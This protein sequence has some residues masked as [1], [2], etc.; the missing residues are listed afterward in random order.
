MRL[1]K[2][3]IDWG[4]GVVALDCRGEGGHIPLPVVGIL[5]PTGSG[6]TMMMKLVNRLFRNSIREEAS[7]ADWKGVNGSV[8]FDLGS[9][10]ATGVVRDGTIVQRL[11][12][13]EMSMS[14][15][16]LMGGILSYGSERG[17]FPVFDAPMTFGER[18]MRGVLHDLY[19]GEVKNSVIWVDDFALGL[20][21][22]LARDFLQTLIK[23]SLERDNQLIVV[24]DREVLLQ[25]IGW[26]N[27]RALRERDTNLVER[28]IKSL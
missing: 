22:S 10:I 27:I 1:R 17:A 4:K 19:K 8:E 11:T 23:K 13:P 9:V 12:F 26:D 7:F 28:V 18:C 20:D 25:G 5:G 2:I 24:S 6:R 21:D 3:E 16:K 15:G 14:E